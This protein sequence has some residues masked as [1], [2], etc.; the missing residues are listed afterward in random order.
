[1][2]DSRTLTGSRD[3]LVVDASRC[4]RMRFSESS[5]RPCADIC[6][7][8]AVTLD[9]GLAIETE[10]CR[11]C[12]L[13][14]AVCPVGALEH[15]SDF[16]ACLAQ[17]SRVPEPILGC[18]RTK[19]YSNSTMTCL[20]G[21]SDEHLLALCHSLPGE[22]AL[23]LTACSEC[24]NS[25]MIP[26]LHQ[27]L[28]ALSEAEVLEGGCR[29]VIAE[30]EA[31]IHFS[32]ESVDRRGFFKSLRSSLFQ[33]ATV[34]LSGS[35]EQTDRRSEYAVKRVPVRRELLNKIVGRLS[36]EL[37]RLVLGLYNRR[38]VFTDNCTTCQGCV[39]ICPTGALQTESQDEQPRFDP[40][41]CTDCGLCVDFCI[42]GA[43]RLDSSGPCR[44][45]KPA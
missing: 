9:G 26:H 32:D 14:T 30:S 2:A 31:D 45:T 38:I 7:H 36:P 44:A 43:V 39:A 5:C 8:G 10:L 41:R 27:R 24:P 25:A 28:A 34:I 42:D 1:M 4:L 33:S 19:E 37:G 17:L 35:K 12:L 3:D 15:G 40:Q 11:G 16:S 20:G 13:C 6:P 29:I 23:N 21:L 22:L 18:I